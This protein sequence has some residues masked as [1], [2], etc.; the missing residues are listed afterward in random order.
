MDESGNMGAAPLRI[1]FY[2]NL[3]GW[4]KRSS[5]G[6]RQWVLTLA[7]GLVERGYAV[8]VLSEAPASR[9]RDEL[10]LDARIGRVVLGIGPLARRRL[11]TYVLG[12]PGVRLVAALNHYN[13][14]AALLKAHLGDAV[15]VTLTQHEHLSA[16]AAWQ[17]PLVYRWIGRHVRRHFGLADAV[18]TV[19]R[20]VAQDLQSH[21]NVPA[22]RLHT[23]YNPAYRPEF[24]EQ[25][26]APIDHPWIG[27]AAA[28]LVLA[29]G[30]LHYVKGYDDLLAAFPRVHR[31]TGARLVILGEGKERHALE[32]QVRQLDSA[33]YVELPGRVAS[34]A[35]WL[36][37]SEVFVLSSR[38]EGLPTVLVEALALGR[39][40]VAT[41]CPSGPEELLEDGRWGTLVDV[42]DVDGLARALVAAICAPAPDAAALRER[43]AAFSLDRALDEYLAIWNAARA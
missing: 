24:L 5:G 31:E 3:M 43:A 17:H 21:W 41:R 34:V 18:V 38:R 9:F 6:V 37:H 1:A 36:A 19:S 8:D 20:G 13:I 16:D 32:A 11:K 27:Q 15:H 23:I 29:A 33:A 12:H 42:G 4:P 35:P 26:R 28:P 39:K 7:N 2:C 14:H 30:R 25:A 10:L 22:A 40:I